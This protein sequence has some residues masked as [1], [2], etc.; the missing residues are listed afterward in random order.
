MLFGGTA[1]RPNDIRELKKLGFDFAEI[2]LS[3]RTNR[4]LWWE[5]GIKN[6]ETGFFL[7]A[8]GPLEAHASMDLDYPSER[9]CPKSQ[10]DSGHVPKNEDS[11]ADYPLSR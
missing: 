10:G 9:L 1:R 5:S 4:R 6:S 7:V 11:T 8:H 3:T 2:V